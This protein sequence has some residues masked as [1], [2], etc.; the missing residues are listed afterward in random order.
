M[1]GDILERTRVQAHVGSG[2]R[3]ARGRDRSDLTPLRR[4]TRELLLDELEVY[5]RAGRFPKN[6]V[7]DE[8]T[9]VFV[10]PSGTHCAI[11]HLMTVGGAGELVRELATTQNY[12]YVPELARDSRVSSWLEAAGFTVEEAARI[13]PSYSYCPS[14]PASCLCQMAG[15]RSLVARGELDGRGRFA[16]AETSG[17]GEGACASIKVGDVVDI[18]YT[19][20]STTQIVAMFFPL[21]GAWSSTSKEGCNAIA[22]F[23]VEADG[24]AT[25]SANDRGGP[26]SL[27]RPLS[28][29]ET[30][31]Y[32][33]T[34]DCAR[35]LA[36]DG[37]EWADEPSCGGCAIAP[38]EPSASAA[39]DLSTIAILTSVLAYRAARRALKR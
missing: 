30:A 13:Q 11:A 39:A 2:E 6:T 21:E 29:A 10:D 16:I 19:P 12:A 26:V 5:W 18:S 32:V 35:W 9:P 38:R 37:S 17:L 20:V 31:A 28:V 22:L 24:S 7:S 4:R 8:L 27:P 33:A 23:G 25:C 34:P 15:R 14:S 1:L 3:L 36:L